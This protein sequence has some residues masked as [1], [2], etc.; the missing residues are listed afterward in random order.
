M[1]E[2]RQPW[3]MPLVGPGDLCAMKA[4]VHASAYLAFIVL[5][6]WA[7]VT[8]LAV[9]LWLRGY[10]YQS[11]DTLQSKTW[12]FSPQEYLRHILKYTKHKYATI[13]HCFYAKSV[14]KY[15]KI[16]NPLNTII[17]VQYY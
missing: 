7:L 16:Y 3:S 2:R 12:S 6:F 15:D 17:T 13:C 8:Y 9:N 1:T 11:K 4:C 14:Q 10:G 5:S